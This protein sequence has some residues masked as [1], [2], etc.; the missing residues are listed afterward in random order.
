MTAKRLW[1]LFLRLLGR[2]PAKPSRRRGGGGAGRRKKARRRETALGTFGTRIGAHAGIYG[3]GQG[4]SL[5]MGLVTLAV[6]TRFLPPA[7]F[8]LYALYYFLALLLAML[9]TVG[10]LRGGLLWVFGGE[11]DEDEDEE[12]GG[13]EDGESAEDKRR[14]LG[15]ALAL[16]ACVATLGT[17]V[18]AAAAPTIARVLAGAA[19]DGRLAILAGVAGAL[20]A[21]WTLAATVP[22]R[23][24][25]PHRYV[26][27]NL[28]RPVL[29]L[30]AT[31][32]LVATNP[33]VGRAV[34]GLTI[35][36]ACAAAVALLAVRRSFSFAFGVEDA[37]NI[38]RIGARYVPLILALWVI[39][40]GGIFLLGQ[41]GTASDVGFLRLATGVAAVASLPVSAF[42]TAWG[43]L[44]KEPIFDAVE[45]ERGKLAASG[46]LATYFAL[47][48]IWIAL[49]LFVGANLLVRI[50]P[51]GYGEAAPLIPLLGLGV[52]L[53]GWFRVIRRTGR[54]PRRRLWYVG[55]AVAAAVVFVAAATLLIPPLGPEG[56]ALAV[57]AAFL[58]AATGIT[59]RS[60]LGP[61]P[62]PLGYGRIAVGVLVA[63]AC[64]A[65]ARPL[66]GAAGSVG[67][68]V[69][70][71][72]LAAYPLILVGTGTVPRAHLMP[73]RRMALAAVPRG[74]ASGRSNGAVDLDGLD[75]VQ[76]A[77]LEVVVRH[78]RPLRDLAPLVGVT[79]DALGADVV[80]AL[81]QLGGAGVG[82]SSGADARIGGYLLSTAPVAARDQLWRRLDS[83]GADAL[84]VDA[85][86][87]TLERLRRAPAGTWP[88]VGP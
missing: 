48:A 8:G 44:R 14:A 60:Q 5:L 50:A 69:A 9:Y 72:A 63:G 82:G 1:D 18:V 12:L 74:R 29:V 64:Y 19:G 81:R 40:N 26:L 21:I 66:E 73:L 55:L 34:L 42:I 6:L 56:A 87:L 57:V 24:R 51:E 32:P 28:G 79:P 41:Y 85:L 20:S 61:H 65:V 75:D 76:R 11:G 47:A 23:E 45:A 30:V 86:S 52:L 36:S 71:A 46:V 13:R 62:I 33:S 35:G 58:F 53:Y 22:R 67:P 7:E 27:L 2:A 25:R 78:R 37:R 16:V 68:L 38:A 83:E 88:G 3:G 39:A 70:L 49:G 31:V 43:P 84:E 80:A 54:F 4:L 17:L 10:W 59:L 77:L 15:T